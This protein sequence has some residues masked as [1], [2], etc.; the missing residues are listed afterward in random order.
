MTVDR[1]ILNDVG[2]WNT[3]LVRHLFS[4][5]EVDFIQR[6]PLSL[7]PS[8]HRLIW[9][10]EKNGQFSVRNAYQLA[11]KE[12]EGSHSGADGSGS[13]NSDRVLW[14]KVWGACVPGKVKILGWRGCLNSLPTRSKLAK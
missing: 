5:E 13:R 14:K 6:I 2:V 10:C 3:S 1:L 4:E 7:R 8:T 9:H 12:V 11:C